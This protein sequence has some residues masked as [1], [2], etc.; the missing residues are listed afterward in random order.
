MK[1]INEESDFEE[2]DNDHYKPD[3]IK[4]LNS[5][6]SIGGTM[7]KRFI[8]IDNKFLQEFFEAKKDPNNSYVSYMDDFIDECINNNQEDIPLKYISVLFKKERL[9]SDYYHI[10]S[11][12][13]GSRLANFLDVPTV[14]NER[15][16]MNHENYIIS[17]DFVKEGQVIDVLE[18]TFARVPID[19]FS[20]FKD[21]DRYL[22]V[23]IYNIMEEYQEDDEELKTMQDNF[24]K[25]FIPHYM[26][27]NMICDDADFKPRNI[28]YIIE[29]NDGKRNMKLAPANDY[30]FIMTFRAQKEMEHATKKNL[31]YL[32]KKYPEETMK[33]V[34]NLKSKVLENNKFNS[35]ALHE[36]FN[37][38]IKDANLFKKREA[39]IKLNLETLFDEYDKL[40]SINQNDIECS[41]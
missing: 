38:V 34:E 13:L 8:R 36:V 5:N 10:T 26:F 41:R 21:W 31:N 25:D 24:V 16:M 39:R 4:Y 40:V 30:E 15:V 35:K 2:Y 7:T 37:S 12:V 14:Y 6:S 29:N 32:L 9:Y 28:N 19:D 23:K 17:V 22:R 20:M 3:N 27:R 1:I 18:D 11:D 33:F